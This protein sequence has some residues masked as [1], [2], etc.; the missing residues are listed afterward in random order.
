MTADLTT[1]V[2][3]RDG[4]LVPEASRALTPNRYHRKFQPHRILDVELIVYH[5]TAG[6][7]EGALR[8]LRTPE[9][10]A[11]AHFLVRR[12]GFVWQLAPLTDR[13]WHA[14]GQTSKWRGKGQVNN[15]SIGIEL[16]NWGLLA[17][18][19]PGVIHTYRQTVYKGPVFKDARGRLWDAYAEPQLRALERLTQLIIAACP[20]LRDA[21]TIGALGTPP[22]GLLI[23]HEHADP[24][25][26]TDPGANFP[27][28]R[29]I[30]AANSPLWPIAQSFSE[31]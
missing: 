25:R 1:L 10:Q 13:T 12:D 27:W 24:V 15:R 8:W 26:K 20:R 2:D 29:I 7:A 16:E 17:E 3:R 9:S 28:A 4:W 19:A 31:K 5:Y 18:P 21:R 6:G 30:K 23:G 11:S 22:S 14:G